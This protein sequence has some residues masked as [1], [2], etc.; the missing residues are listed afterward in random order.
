MWEHR[1]LTTLWASTACYT[2]SF[3][4][5]TFT[6]SSTTGYNHAP[7]T[8]RAV[9]TD[10]PRALLWGAIWTIGYW[11]KTCNSGAREYINGIFS[12]RCVTLGTSAETKFFTSRVH[13]LLMCT[14]ILF[15]S[16]MRTFSYLY[17]ASNNTSVFKDKSEVRWPW[18]SLRYY[19]SIYC[20]GKLHEYCVLLNTKEL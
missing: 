6:E 17:T 19:P 10:L 15:V 7:R 2:D 20:T 1:R 5:Y 12:L 16:Y 18:C 8:K 3:T 13:F 14:S 9:I 4:F 11:G